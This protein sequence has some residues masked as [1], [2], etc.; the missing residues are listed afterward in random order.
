MGAIGGQF[1]RRE[2]DGPV[3]A[4]QGRRLRRAAKG[5]GHR[6]PR[7]GRAGDGDGEA[8][9]GLGRVDPVVVRDGVGD[10]HRGRRG[11]DRD[12]PRSRGARVARHVGG[13]RAGGL[14][15]AVPKGSCL[16]GDGPVALPVGLTGAGHAADGHGDGRAGLGDAGDGHARRCL[17]RVDGVVGR[18]LRDLRRP[19]GHK[20]DLEGRSPR[21]AGVVGRVGGGGGD[22]GACA[23]SRQGGAVDGDLP[24]PLAVHRVVAQRGFAERH[25][26]DRANLPGA[27]D[28]DLPT[29]FR[30]IHRSVAGDGG[31][32][33]GLGGRGVDGDGPGQDA[34]G[35]AA[36]FAPALNLQLDRRAI[37]RPVAGEVGRPGPVLVHR[38]RFGPVAEGHGDAA[39]D[40]AGAADDEAVARGIRGIDDGIVLQPR[41]GQRRGRDLLQLVVVDF[42][43]VLPALDLLGEDGGHH[44]LR[45]FDDGG[46]IGGAAL[47]GGR[48]NLRVR[49][50]DEA[51]DLARV[52]SGGKPRLQRRLDRRRIFQRRPPLVR[53]GD[54]LRQGPCHR[55][56]IRAGRRGDDQ[57]VGDLRRRRQRRR[58]GRIGRVVGRLDRIDRQEVGGKAEFPGERRGGAFGAHAAARRGFRFD[59]GLNQRRQRRDHQRPFR[60]GH[61]AAE[62]RARGN[63]DA[64]DRDKPAAAGQQRHV[65]IAVGIGPGGG[66]DPDVVRAVA[67]A[68]AEHQCIGDVAV[69]DLEEQRCRLRRWL[70]LRRRYGRRV[71]AFATT[72]A[73]R[74]AQRGKTAQRGGPAPGQRRGAGG[75]GDAF[76]D[77]GAD[78]HLARGGQL[79]LGRR[80]RHRPAVREVE[81]RG[82][83][84]QQR[85]LLDPG[86]LGGG[87]E[88][89][90]L[91]Q[92]GERQH[93]HRARQPGRRARR[94]ALQE[95]RLRRGI[96]RQRDPPQATRRG[97]QPG[98]RRGIGD[99]DALQRLA[100]PEGRAQEAWTQ[101]GA[102]GFGLAGKVGARGVTH[103]KTSGLVRTRHPPRRRAQ[104]SRPRR[105]R[106][107]PPRL[108]RA[109]AATR[110]SRHS[111]DPARAKAVADLRL[112]YVKSSAGA[113][114]AP[115][116]A[117]SGLAFAPAART[118]CAG[119]RGNGAWTWRS[120]T[121]G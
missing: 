46:G 9:A 8:G 67:V 25:G 6:R 30:D 92:R 97:R 85:H 59:K 38:H 89:R 17:G 72:A 95:F 86:D 11:I 110:L 120:A 80:H 52:R 10:R 22:R 23:V 104:I 93:Q 37:G 66:L 113:A 100:E 112:S 58:A 44:G 57:R 117:G 118:T 33:G 4:G 75:G 119:H 101:A 15:N 116:A 55:L 12:C 84:G 106:N 1:V 49:R 39:A 87:D 45:V 62:R 18:D 103:G 79:H 76:G 115:E 28:G 114:A 65:E 121:G 32:R 51:G 83:V 96:G 29:V 90:T 48:R 7:L 53:A 109:G 41:R 64:P 34:A 88:V 20:V 3:G 107:P 71:V 111:F 68:V 26:H 36:V 73:A 42:G 91:R 47:R 69:A 99:G 27:G 13:D 54:A 31:D 98:Q 19:W 94:P 24:P 50:R 35:N 40:P 70:R 105:T 2:V 77:R 16:E 78:H 61:D 21:H 63:V 5:D 60:G 43:Q 56:A 14:I 81:P 108:C 74:S 82:P 102:R